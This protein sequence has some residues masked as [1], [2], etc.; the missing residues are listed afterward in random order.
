MHTFLK[1]NAIA[2]MLLVV[3]VAQAGYAHN[4]RKQANENWHELQTV[5]RELGIHESNLGQVAT[6]TGQ[7]LTESE[8]GIALVFHILNE[9]KDRLVDDG[10][11]VTANKAVTTPRWKPVTRLPDVDDGRLIPQPQFSRAYLNLRRY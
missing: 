10:A 9:K 1:E 5:Q 8:E 3:C 2:L 4:T 7:R 11:E 6:Q